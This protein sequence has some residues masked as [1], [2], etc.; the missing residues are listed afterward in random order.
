MSNFESQPEDVFEADSSSDSDV[1]DTRSEMDFHDTGDPSGSD[2]SMVKGFLERNWEHLCD[3]QEEE[4]VS[5]GGQPGFG[6]HDM[7]DYWQK[8]GVPDAIGPTT[9][10]PRTDENELVHWTG[11]RY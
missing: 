4:N 5:W 2:L 6:L 9:P 10:L 8:L 11:P 3:C 7:A 1:S